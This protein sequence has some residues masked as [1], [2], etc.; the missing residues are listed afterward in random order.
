MVIA[1]CGYVNF[2]TSLLSAILFSTK[3]EKW[4]EFRYEFNFA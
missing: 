3:Q 1:T 2:L 4:A